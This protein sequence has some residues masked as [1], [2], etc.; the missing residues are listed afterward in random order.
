MLGSATMTTADGASLGVVLMAVLCGC[1][2]EWLGVP[3][4]P[5]GVEA[6]SQEDIQR[7]LFALLEAGPGHRRNPEAATW[8]AK[9]LEQMG[10]ELLDT[11]NDG[12]VCGLREGRQAGVLL[13]LSEPGPAGASQAALP[14]AQLISL[15]KSVHGLGRPRRGLAFCSLPRSLA[16]AAP[17]EAAGGLALPLQDRW[18]IEGVAVLG[19]EPPAGWAPAPDWTRAESS[20]LDPEQ[21]GIERMNHERVAEQLRALH[22]LLLAPELS[23]AR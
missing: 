21:D 14:D 11:D 12:L 4:P 3:I 16:G 17:L 22:R 15:A 18:P 23:P 20:S 13:L 19:G 6:I 8:V 10:L 1:P 7:D 5:R 2:A 9:R